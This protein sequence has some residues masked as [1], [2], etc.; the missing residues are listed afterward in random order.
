MTMRQM[1]LSCFAV[2]LGCIL[3]DCSRGSPTASPCGTLKAGAAAGEAC[4]GAGIEILRRHGAHKRQLH[5][6]MRIDAARHDILP[7][8]IDDFRVAR[9]VDIVAHR[10]DHPLIA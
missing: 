3:M 4:G 9:R 1:F 8:R 6:R 5:M 2:A 7:A 10:D